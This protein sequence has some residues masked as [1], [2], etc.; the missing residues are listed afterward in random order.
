MWIAGWNCQPAEI[1]WGCILR[2]GNS[3]S[4][5]SEVRED[6]VSSEHV[7]AEEEVG[8]KETGVE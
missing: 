2:R 6:R 5:G 3:T 7:G 1:R 8:G 4:W